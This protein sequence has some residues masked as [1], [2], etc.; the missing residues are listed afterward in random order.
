M[1]SWIANEIATKKIYPYNS[2]NK[3]FQGRDFGPTKKY[4]LE[5]SSHD[6][7]REKTEFTTN[8]SFALF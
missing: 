6:R 3:N 4:K 8:L 5:Q 7:R 1:N 2:S